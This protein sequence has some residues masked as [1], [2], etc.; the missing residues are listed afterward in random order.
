MIHADRFLKDPSCRTY[1]FQTAQADRPLVAQF[2]GN[3]AQ[4][5]LAAAKLVQD[6]CD[7]IDLNLG[8]P[9]ASL[10]ALLLYE[11]EHGV[12][13]CILTS[14]MQ[15]PS[16]RQDS[17]RRDGYGAFTCDSIGV[18]GVAHIVRT[19]CDGLKVPVFCKIRILENLQV[20]LAETQTQQRP[21][22]KERE[23]LNRIF[24]IWDTTTIL[25]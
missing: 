1:Y 18:E 19:L 24:L 14:L 3:D 13:T 17:A 25:H 21:N 8:C 10:F 22:L 9:Q 23:N 5:I 4:T 6:K 7:A 20:E 11:I 16:Q 12:G 2:C 15:P